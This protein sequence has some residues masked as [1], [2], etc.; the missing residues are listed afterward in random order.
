MSDE[1]D[2]A[3]AVA[4]TDE[5]SASPDEGNHDDPAS[6]IANLEQRLKDT[7]RKVTVLGNEKAEL[8]GKLSAFEEVVPRPQ[9]DPPTNY[10]EGLDEEEL[11][12][13]PGLLVPRIQA[14]QQGLVN[15]VAEV[16][17]SVRDELASMIKGQNPERLAM[18]DRIEELKQDPELKGFSDDALLTIAKRD[19]AR[20][21]KKKEDDDG[22]IPSAASGN[23]RKAQMS[24]KDIK[25]SPLYQQIYGDR[26]EEKGE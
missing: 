20:A 15:D 13:N 18:A 5:G 21:P 16:I 24:E 23:H 2:S 14:S 4:P 19:A 11:A 22:L 9:A 10:W 6:Q 25:Q 17:K 7:Q 8:S 12:L 1:L 3:A 26:F